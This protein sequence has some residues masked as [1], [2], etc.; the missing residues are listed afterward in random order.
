MTILDVVWVAITDVLRGNTGKYGD[1]TKLYEK[2]KAEEDSGVTG[3]FLTV[4]SYGILMFYQALILFFYLLRIH[5]NGHMQDVYA[6]LNGT[7]FSFFIPYDTEVS[8]R[9][10]KY[11][12]R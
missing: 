5:M 11:A 6:R 3:I 7:E 1:C 9:E 8:W 10:V 2:F 4:T 12:C